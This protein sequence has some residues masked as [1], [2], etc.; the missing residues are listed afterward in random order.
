[1]ALKSFIEKERRSSTIANFCDIYSGIVIFPRW[2][3]IKHSVAATA[4]A[5]GR[6]NERHRAGLSRHREDMMR[7]QRRTARYYCAAKLGASR[8]PRLIAEDD[9]TWWLMHIARK[10]HLSIE[11]ESWR[12]QAEASSRYLYLLIEKKYMIQRIKMTGLHAQGTA[13]I[14]YKGYFMH[15]HREVWSGTVFQTI[16]T[17][18]KLSADIRQR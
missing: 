15:E 3:K 16:R 13:D 11:R 17:E 2:H 4:S 5:N 7:Y 9:F 10:E 1:M 14:D 6:G 12:E 8:M 18:L